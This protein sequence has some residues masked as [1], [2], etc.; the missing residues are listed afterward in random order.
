MR[1]FAGV[2]AVMILTQAPVAADKLGDHEAWDELASNQES[3]VFGRFIGRFDSSQ[4]RSRRILLR[5]VNTGEKEQLTVGDGLGIIVETIPPGVYDLLGFEAVY[6]ARISGPIQLDRHRPIRQRFAVKPKTGDAQTS[7]IVVPSNR[8]VYVGTIGVDNALDGLVYRGHQLRVFDDYDEAMAR[9]TSLYPALVGS[10]ERSGIVPARHF[11]LKPSRRAEPFERVV[12]LDNPMQQARDY[13]GDGKYRQAIVWLETFMPASDAERSE[14]KLLVGEA[15]LGEGNYTDAI[16][17]L[18]G[19]LLFD[20]NDTRA[21][22]LLARAHAYEGNLEDAQN[23]YEALAQMLTG[24]AEAHLHLGYLYALQDESERAGEQFRAAFETDFDYLLHDFAPFFIA[25][26]EALEQESGEYLPPRVIKYSV[27]PP[28]SMDSRRAAT[29]DGFSV[30]IDHEGNVIA[31]QIGAQ[32][33][34]SAPLTMLSLVKATYEPASLNGIPIPAL[35]R[36]GDV[37]SQ[38]Q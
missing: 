14:V 34:G 32:S 35:V 29:R 7:R 24:D 31:A 1:K 10:L 5:E 2:L 33:G 19:V 18:G 20:A 9:L 6:Y 8:P 26:R 37:G 25:L 36:M 30:L 12:G 4:F 13:I 22:R 28:R 17:E 27:P 16:E 21:L 11:M 3:L 23:L 38:A 15:L